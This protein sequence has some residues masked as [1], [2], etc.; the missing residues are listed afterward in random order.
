M[1]IMKIAIKTEYGIFSSRDYRTSRIRLLPTKL[2][3]RSKYIAGFLNH[4]GE[5]LDEYEAMKEAR[6]HNQVPN[7]YCSAKQLLSIHLT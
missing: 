1:A 5:F 4:K 3:K 6:E 2:M 7:I